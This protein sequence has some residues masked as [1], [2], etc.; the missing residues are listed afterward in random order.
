MFSLWKTSGW[1][2]A[3]LLTLAPSGFANAPVQPN[4]NMPE[5]GAVNYVEGHVA[6]NGKTLARS[7][8]GSEMLSKGQA[9]QTTNGRT[10][11]LLTPGVYV[12][13]GDNSSVKLVSP[14]LTHPTVALNRGE[15]L[16]EVD[17]THKESRL[18]VVDNGVTVNLQ[19]KGIYEFRANP[20]TVEVYDGKVAVQ[21]PGGPYH[22]TKGREA[23][24]APD[25]KI[26]PEKFDRKEADELYAWSK[27]RSEYEAEASQ[28][29]AQAVVVDPYAYAGWGP[30][31]FWDPYFGMYDFF[32]YDGYM[33]GSFGY[34]FYSPIY[35]GG[36]F[37]G[38]GYYGGGYY[39]GGY[40]G[41]PWA[42]TPLGRARSIGAGRV[43]G[44]GGGRVVGRGGFAGA[45]VGGG[46]QG[47]RFGGGSFGGGRIGG[48]GRMMGGGGFGGRR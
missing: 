1:A 18:N 44:F 34:P 26:K 14:D 31:W 23:L 46:F 21:E 8:V 48:G 36:G 15:A 40:Y 20:A 29:M 22:V 30:G 9:L 11:M 5:P 19:K 47:G 3:A 25:T 39:G 41:R 7:Q 4:Q 27:L 17:E 24:L 43:G 32:P 16:I 6:V 42:R 33:T 35:W 45:R 38:G 28:D 2:C 12:R 37:Y 13:L 10:E